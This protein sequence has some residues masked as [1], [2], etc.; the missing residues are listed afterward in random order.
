[1]YQWRV[2]LQRETS[3]V[4]DPGAGEVS[5]PRPC[6][7]ER[8]VDPRVVGSDLQ[9]FLVGG[10]R[11]GVVSRLAPPVSQVAQSQRPAVADRVLARSQGVESVPEEA[12]HPGIVAA[13]QVERREREGLHAEVLGERESLDTPARGLAERFHVGPK[14]RL[15]QVG[16]AR[17]LSDR[18]A[19]ARA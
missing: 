15:D 1:M 11:R 17:E 8:E 4:V 3:L 14:V 12:P 2:R 5:G 18:E 7:A 9:R 6:D 19:V 10:D 16:Q 13:R